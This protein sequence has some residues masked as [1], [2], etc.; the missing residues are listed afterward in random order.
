MRKSLLAVALATALAGCA[1]NQPAPPTLDLP[2]ATESSAQNAVLENWWTA[3]DDPALTTLIDEALANNLD[4]RATLARIE[5]ARAQILLARSNLYPSVNLNADAGRSRISGAGSQRLP[6]GTPLV[7]NNYAV[8]LD[9]SY[10]LD[11]WGKYRSGALAAQ[12][13][14][15]AARYYREAV[16]ITVVGD[17]AGAYFRLRAADAELALL[18]D[19]LASRRD[20]LSLQRDRFD[21][22]IVGE[23]D[24]RQAEAEV[25]AVVA[26]IARAR[27]GI[28]QLESALAVLTGRSPRAVF[29]PHVARGQPVLQ[30]AGLPPLPSGLPS[31]VLERR[32]DIRRSEALL[33]A[34]DLRISEARADYFPSLSLTAAF[35]SESAALADLFTSPASVWRFGLALVQPIIGI[36]KVD[37]SVQAATARRDQLLVEYQQ[38]VQTAFR[39]VHD[40]LVTNRTSREVL[41]AESARRDQLAAALDVAKLRY[42]AGRTSFLEVLDAQRTLLLAET[43]RIVAARDAKLS[44]VDFA[45]AVGGGW[46]PEAFAAAK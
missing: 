26:N 18:Q 24:L 34:S 10:E 16:R 23:Y 12:N 36:K 25:S 15:T 14:L 17:V 19:T 20:T 45:K 22:G 7:S 21:A 8:G 27:R 35:G 3:F 32:P 5:L 44:L 43:Q 2:A 13:D 11:V 41:D 4:L 39:E 46:S 42:E 28:G 6:A 1:V 31:G 33:A 37:A 29:A 38:T 30:S 9:L 40:A